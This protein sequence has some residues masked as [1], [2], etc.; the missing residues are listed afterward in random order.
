YAKLRQAATDNYVINQLDNIHPWTA[1]DA[2]FCLHTAGVT[3]SI[4]VSPT[5]EINRLDQ[6]Q[7]G[8]PLIL[9]AAVF[10]GSP[11][12]FPGFEERTE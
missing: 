11:R 6:Y 5:N 10:S 7:G 9:S 8:S 12:K 1:M 2:I 3:G 4:P